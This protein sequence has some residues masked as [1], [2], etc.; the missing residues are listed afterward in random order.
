MVKIIRRVVSLILLLGS[1]LLIVW[2][3]IRNPHQFLTQPVSYA[4][5]INTSSTQGITSTIM[6][7]HQV[8]F[9]WP[10]S[11]RIGDTEEVTLVLEPV[12]GEKSAQTPSLVSTDIYSIYN[13][14]AE[15]RFEVAGVTV[16]PA[17][18]IRESMPSGQTVK[19]KWQ[20]S[21]DQVGSYD[22]KVWLSLRLLPLDGSQ[23]SE[24]PIYIRELRLQATSL[25]GMNE[26][27]VYIIGG[28]GVV[29]SL[30]IEYGDMIGWMRMR[31]RKITTK[32]TTDTQDF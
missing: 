6:D 26:A 10:R 5:T 14:M 15:A 2:A 31:K 20:I 22:G 7:M 1:G 23:V 12:T 17:N 24:V 29:L 9:E 11:M 18:P 8:V 21:T 32:D 28:A 4:E 3:S 25:F 27:M 13:I 16:N 30:V 19:F